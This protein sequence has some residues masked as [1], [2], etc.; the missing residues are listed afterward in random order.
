MGSDI[1]AAVDAAQLYEKAVLIH[2]RIQEEYNAAAESAA[3]SC[4]A[5]HPTATPAVEG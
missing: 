3:Q 5:S 1:A 4:A 2:D